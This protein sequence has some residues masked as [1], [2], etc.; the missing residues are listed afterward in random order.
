[1]AQEKETGDMTA[2]I[3]TY[4]KE[5]DAR[6]AKLEEDLAEARKRREKADYVNSRL[7]PEP[8]KEEKKEEEPPKPILPPHFAG[9]WERY[10]PTCG[11][12]NPG[13]KDETVCK[14]CGTHLGAAADIKTEENPGGVVTACWNCGGK[15]AK[16]IEKKEV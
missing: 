1:M 3:V 11:E 4:M 5:K 15:K 12:Q 9:S 6:I 13:F 16:K 7:H 10:C 2:N 14:D 8:A